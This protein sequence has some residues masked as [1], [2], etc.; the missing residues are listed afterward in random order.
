MLPDV[1]RISAGFLAKDKK[2]LIAQRSDTLKWEFPGGKLNDNE[3]YDVALIREFKEEFAID[4]KVEQE[5][6][7]A[8]VDTDKVLI[9]M[10]FTVTGDP[11]KINLKVHKDS[12]LVSLAELKVLDLSDADK[13]F[14]INFENEIKQLID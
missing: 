4:I 10:F 13:D 6:G 3:H 9:V 2:V 1:I 5:I 14:V 11:D 8:E 12:K 7:S